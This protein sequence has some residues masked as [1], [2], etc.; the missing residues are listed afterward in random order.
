M[1]GERAADCG[2]LI[3]TGADFPVLAFHG[4]RSEQ[5]SLV[6]AILT[7]FNQECRCHPAADH[8]GNVR[9]IHLCPPHEFIN[10]H[11]ETGRTV[12]WTVPV[13]HGG[14]SPHSYG[15]LANVVSR[16]DRMMFARRL[17]EK[18]LAQEGILQHCVSCQSIYQI[19]HQ[20]MPAT[21]KGTLP[22]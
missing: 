7:G 14:F 16:A 17:R 12:E 4:T 22:W 20:C 1:T 8:L 13:I 5:E 2:F 6:N 15:A 18:W 10:E 21:S 11:D 3:H 9:E 19:R